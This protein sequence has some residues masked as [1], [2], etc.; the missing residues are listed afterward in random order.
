M[1]V[2]GRVRWLLGPESTTS[3]AD[4]LP[5]HSHQTRA[6]RAGRVQAQTE[7][8][9]I[10]P[11]HSFSH[12]RV[13]RRDDHDHGGMKPTTRRNLPDD[14][15]DT[16]RSRSERPD[17]APT[18]TV[19]TTTRPPTRRQHDHPMEPTPRRPPRRLPPCPGWWVGGARASPAVAFAGGGLDRVTDCDRGPPPTTRKPTQVAGAIHG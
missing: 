13:P 14:R 1:I 10:P 16:T 5:H 7:P 4:V 6:T 11:R 3:G 17:G 15:H 19:A 9:T 18:R 2:I 12:G 8:L